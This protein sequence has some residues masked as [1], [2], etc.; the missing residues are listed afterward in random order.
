MN[1]D[2]HLRTFH[3]QKDLRHKGHVAISEIVPTHRISEKTNRFV[4][5][6]Q[7]AY[8]IRQFLQKNVRILT[9]ENQDS[10]SKTVTLYAYKNHLQQ[11]L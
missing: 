9:D 8:Q 6:P 10:L 11:N 1:K 5:F 4:L 3:Y 7:L 2:A